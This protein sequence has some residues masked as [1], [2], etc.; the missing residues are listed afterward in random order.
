M[1][2][3]GTLREVEELGV[4]FQDLSEES[5]FTKAKDQLSS[6]IHVHWDQKIVHCLV[7]NIAH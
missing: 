4:I 2:V 6:I 3:R 7:A 5:A 1:K